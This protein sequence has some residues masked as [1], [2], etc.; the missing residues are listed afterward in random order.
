MYCL[1]KLI[2]FMFFFHLSAEAQTN[3]VPITAVSAAGGVCLLLAIAL[4]VVVVQVK[5]RFKGPFADRNKVYAMERFNKYVKEEN[6]NDGF[7]QDD[8]EKDPGKQDINMKAS[9]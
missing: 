7:T 3:M 4:A 6:D 5:K 2:S 9:A 1:S 8:D